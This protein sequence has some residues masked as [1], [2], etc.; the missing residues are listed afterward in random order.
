MNPYRTPGRPLHEPDDDPPIVWPS[1]KPSRMADQLP[2][3]KRGAAAV[4]EGFLLELPHG[5][6]GHLDVSLQGDLLRVRISHIWAQC[7]RCHEGLTDVYGEKTRMPCCATVAD[8]QYRASELRF[9]ARALQ[10]QWD[11]NRERIMRV[12]ALLKRWIAHKTA[13]PPWQKPFRLPEQTTGWASC[14]SSKEQCSC[15]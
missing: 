11:G 10:K 9:S 1:L 5:E 7:P 2:T 12:V 13:R 15:E 4:I 3:P 6:W 8:V 14:V